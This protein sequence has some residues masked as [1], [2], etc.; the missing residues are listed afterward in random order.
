[1]QTW[2]FDPGSCDESVACKQMHLWLKLYLSWGRSHRRD[3]T[4]LVWSHNRIESL[5]QL[6]VLR[7]YFTWS[8]NKPTFKLFVDWSFQLTLLACYL[9]LWPDSADPAGSGS[10][11]HGEAKPGYQ[12]T[13][14]Q[15]K[16]TW[17]VTWTHSTKQPSKH[18]SK[19]IYCIHN[20]YRSS[21]S[22]AI[23]ADAGEDTVSKRAKD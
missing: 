11:E 15:A 21:F 22:W 20:S 16:V 10:L 8:D 7:P 2:D 17:K 12:N 13:E 3:R 18:A 4:W 5:W 19:Q 23:C 1:M 6:Q 14:G 9:P